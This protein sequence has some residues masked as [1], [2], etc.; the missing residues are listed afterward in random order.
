MIIFTPNPVYQYKITLDDN[1][2]KFYYYYYWKIEML[3]VYLKNFKNRLWII[4][5]QE[6]ILENFYF[7]KI[8]PTHTLN[9]ISLLV[10]S[11]FLSSHCYIWQIF[12]RLWSF[13]GLRGLH[14]GSGHDGSRRWNIQV[15]SINGTGLYLSRLKS[16]GWFGQ[17]RFGRK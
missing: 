5:L 15:L 16:K 8:Y 7:L 1:F 3:S 17:S 12:S 4:D 13:N 9:H 10:E 11:I 2:W 14:T 6:N